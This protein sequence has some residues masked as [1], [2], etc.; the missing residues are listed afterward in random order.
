MDPK[1][2]AEQALLTS[3]HKPR[4]YHKKEVSKAFKALNISDAD[5]R[6]YRIEHRGVTEEDMVTEVRELYH[7]RSTTSEA[8][9][10][11]KNDK[12]QANA[13]RRRERHTAAQALYQVQLKT[14]SEQLEGDILRISDT[15]KDD[16]LVVKTTTDEHFGRLRSKPWLIA[17]SH[18]LVDDAWRALEQLWIQRTLTIVS[19]GESLEAIEQSRSELVGAELRK[20]TETCVAAAYV[21][22]PEVERLI[23]VEA[24]ELNIVLI[25]NRRSHAHLLSRLLKEDVHKFVDIRTAWEDCERNWRALNHDH[26][27]EV[28]QTTLTSPLYMAPPSLHAILSQLRDA[29]RLVHEN[30][31]LLLL[32]QLD[33]HGANLPSD[34][35]QK[36]VVSFAEMYKKEEERN[37]TY[38]DMLFRCQASIVA[39]AVGL[40]EQLR[41]TCHRVGAKA[42]EGCLG[43]HAAQLAAFLGNKDLDDFFRIA[44]GLRSEL[45]SIEERLASPEMIYQANVAALEPRVGLLVHALPLESILDAQ[46]K[47][48]ERKTLQGTLERLRKAPKN[49]ILSILPLVHAQTVSLAAIQ[50]LHPMLQSELEEIAKRLDILM[51]EN[52]SDA[53]STHAA[54]IASDPPGSAASKSKSIGLDAFQIIDIQGIR[55]AQRRLGTLVYASDL[56]PTVQSLLA[57]ILDA[58]RVQGHANDVVDA[59]VATECDGLIALREAEMK[60]LLTLVGAGL[61]AQT[62]TLHL[63][64]DRVTRFVHKAVTC[65]E[66]YEERTR[67]VNLTVLDLLDTLKESHED[68]V[69]ALEEAFS[70]RRS[71]LRH[72][73]DEA[74]LEAEFANCLGLLERIDDEYRKY[75]K[76]VTLASTNHPI[77]ITRQAALYRNMLSSHFGVVSATHD[78]ETDIDALVSAECIERAINDPEPVAAAVIEPE[79]PAPV[80]EVPPGPTPRNGKKELVTPGRAVPEPAMEAGTGATVSAPTKPATPAV[81]PKKE[82]RVCSSDELLEFIL[83]HKIL[84]PGEEPSDDDV[85]AAPDAVNTDDDTAMIHDAVSSELVAPAVANVPALGDVIVVLT[86]PKPYLLSLLEQLR[87]AMLASFESKSKLHVQ[88]AKCDADAHVEEYAFLLE[89]CLRMHWPRKGRTDVQIYQPR[90]GELVS[91]RQ[92]H[93]RH[94]KNILKKLTLQESAFLELHESALACVRNQENILLGLQAQLL[95]QTSLAALQGLE[96][97]SKTTYV[98][99]KSAWANILSTKMRVYLTDEPAALAAMCRELVTTC[100]HHIFPDLNSVEVIS[101]CDYHPDE[102]K[103]VQSLVGETE[104]TIQKAVAHRKEMID[105][106]EGLEQG[107]LSLLATFKTRY[108]AC[109]Q[110]LSIKEGLG[111]KYGMPRRNAQERLRSEMSRSDEMARS[112]E[113][114][115]STL[116]VMTT[117]RECALKGPHAPSNLVRQLRSVILELRHIMYTRGLYLGVL[118]NKMQVAPRKVPDDLEATTKYD[119]DVRHEAIADIKTF[120]EWTVQFEA[121]CIADTKSL[122][123]AEGKA[124]ELPPDGV[125]DTLKE[126]LAD[127]KSKA[128]I[129]VHAQIKAFKGQVKAFAAVLAVAPAVA[130]DNIVARAKAAVEAKVHGL[131]TAFEAERADWEAQK[132]RHKSSLTPDLCSPNRVAAVEALCAKEAARTLQVQAAIRNVRWSVLEEH[133][134]NARVVHK[135]LLAAFVSLME[136]LDSCVMPDDL[137][138]DE[139]GDEEEKKRKSLKRLRKALRK[140]EHGDPLAA[141]LSID[142]RKVLDA[143]KETQRFPKRAW[144]GLPIVAAFEIPLAV[145][146]DTKGKVFAAEVVDGN[147]A[148]VAYLTEAHRAAVLGRDSTY[149]AYRAYCAA[150]IETWTKHYTA[151]LTEEELWFLNWGKLI[152]SMRQD[153]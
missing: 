51:Q 70:A 128:T 124:M 113:S 53:S 153:S 63:S 60:A 15:I 81:K 28:F 21:L 30:E 122:F 137:A 88:S 105:A 97:R 102:V 140:V 32:Q 7:Q 150:A 151:L 94:I 45:A 107:I 119:T 76:K 120:M 34:A 65:L 114:L 13:M 12:I 46:G 17:A 64:C 26:A 8:P 130:L 109:I 20:L 142:E 27:I 104:A 37:A 29:Q 132:Q 123:Q 93:G 62:T 129:Y 145:Q 14:I 83:A 152:Q 118:K 50:G 75:N 71:A 38:F 87:N 148:M 61:E 96:S 89:E 2:T 110:N 115:L 144:P 149:N 36:L 52:S 138:K 24:H 74:A 100:S 98:E 23:E 101:G 67:V 1:F 86:V 136:I 103:Y 72:A 146:E 57:V 79:P 84:L 133:I 49:E 143:A 108:Q 141:A 112:I 48:N 47:S 125:P 3:L 80:V 42:D 25:T 41:A 39:D 111:Q 91:H 121:Q 18:D 55:K 31:R 66:A 117:S 6:S 92:R 9:A 10:E 43:Q 95:M 78:D 22:P 77:A 116:R 106:L 99:F 33:Q 40:R 131:V 82:A 68:N 126:Y 127:Q 54:T 73:P 139:D 44:G 59:I 135:R 35:I 58:L 69:A 85:D 134:G 19:F 5:M 90:A 4:E 147:G 11:K 16:L 56:P